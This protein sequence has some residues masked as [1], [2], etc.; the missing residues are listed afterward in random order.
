[1]DDEEEEEEVDDIDEEDEK[2]DPAEGEDAS[3]EDEVTWEK[4]MNVP[5]A[6]FG[7]AF[8]ISFLNSSTSPVLVKCRS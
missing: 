5:P 1:M 6:V 4:D 2:D 8:D 7:F 3:Y